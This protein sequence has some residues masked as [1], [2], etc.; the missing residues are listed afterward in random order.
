MFLYDY[1][2]SDQN[3]LNS[4]E[5]V[6]CSSFALMFLVLR[7]GQSLFEPALISA[8]KSMLKHARFQEKRV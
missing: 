5:N 4:N 8:T 3:D 2:L 6:F 1:N 7:H